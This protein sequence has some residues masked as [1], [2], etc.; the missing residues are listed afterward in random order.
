MDECRKHIR[1]IIYDRKK[2]YDASYIKWNINFP[3]YFRQIERVK[4]TSAT[5]IAS[6]EEELT[7][8]DKHFSAM[9]Q[10][11]TDLYASYIGASV[12]PPEPR[13]CVE[14][15]T[16][17]RKTKACGIAIAQGLQ[18]MNTHVFERLLDGSF[19]LAVDRSYPEKDAVRLSAE[20]TKCCANDTTSECQ[21]TSS[22]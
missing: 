13:S 21:P 3:N 19:L 18:Q 8:I 5:L 2:N 4:K 20:I 15:V 7:N 10:C 17:V 14:F 6:I 22:K 12:P 1:E 9:D 16:E 11:L